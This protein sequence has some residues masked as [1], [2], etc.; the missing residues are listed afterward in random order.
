MIYLF[1]GTPGSG[2]SL[3][4][5]Q[6]I[7][8]TL[9]YKRLPVVANF[10]INPAT[11]GYKE[12]FWYV[13][14][15][16]LSP[17]FLLD[18]ARDYWGSSRV[19]EDS[20]L[21]ALDEAQLL[22]NSRSWNEVTAGASR[23]EWIEFF[24]QHRHFG[25]KIVFVAQNDRMMDRQIRSLVEIEEKHRRLSNFGFKGK[26][27]SLPFAGKLF[28]CVRYYYGLNEKVGMTWMLPKRKYFRLYDS[29]NRF[30]RA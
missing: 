20:I 13:P 18:F 10:D 25:Y 2:K 9:R 6:L 11:K 27:L 5:A 7:Y 12:R 19:V 8:D 14:N 21:L 16:E 4:L 26:L 24:S 29:Y 17:S 28:G 30:G 23:M 15:G 1:S 22:F 3:H